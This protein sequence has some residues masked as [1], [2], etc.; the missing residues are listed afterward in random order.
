MVFNSVVQIKAEI[1]EMRR[2]NTG[3]SSRSLRRTRESVATSPSPTDPG[4][5]SDASELQPLAAEVAALV[6]RL[7]A[8][9]ASGAGIDYVGFEDRFRGDSE[10]LEE[11]Q[12]RYVS[13]FPPRGTRSNRRHR[14]RPRRDARAPAKNRPRVL[15][16][17]ST[18]GWSRSATTKACQLFL[19]TVFNF[20]RRH[21]QN[22]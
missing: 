14:M 2:Q 15:G 17:E 21:L 4:I 12:E 10:A 7:G 9:G 16:V 11:S 19:E 22:R 6:A 20:F 1:E 8:I 18:P 3:S 13:L 5:G